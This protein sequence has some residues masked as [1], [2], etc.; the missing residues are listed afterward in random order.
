MAMGQRVKLGVD[1]GHLLKT[2]VGHFN[3]IM[4][5][6]FTLSFLPVPWRR[7]RKTTSRLLFVYN[8]IYTCERGNTQ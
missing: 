8:Y 6:H 7:H 5:G 2:W 3:M 4:P 1:W